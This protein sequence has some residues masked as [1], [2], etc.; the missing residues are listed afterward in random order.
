MTSYYGVSTWLNMYHQTNLLWLLCG[1]SHD[2]CT[3]FHEVTYW[4]WL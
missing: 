3:F 1:S 2:F 4:I